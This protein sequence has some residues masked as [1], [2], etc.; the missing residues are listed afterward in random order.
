[1]SCALLD[2]MRFS[3]FKQRRALER[4]SHE[5]REL[6]RSKSRFTANIHHELRTPLTLML[7]PLE[8][9][10]SGDFGEIPKPVVAAMRTMRANGLRLL[11]LI[12]NLLDLAKIENESLS[13]RRMPVRLVERVTELIEGARPMAERKGIELRLEGF[14]E[15][16]VVYVDSDAFEKI[17][18]N[19]VGNSLKFTDQGQ[20]VVSG[21]VCDEGVHISVADTGIGI[22]REQLDKVF[23][24]FAQVARARVGARECTSCC[25]S[26]RPMPRKMR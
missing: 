26:G 24:R 8:A 11:K 9:L 13:I 2:R 20:I 15:M 21:E 12:N 22:P 6:D 7:S 16:P 14:E 23:D 1:M 17:V 18:V 4:A 3:D 19:L 5:L 10:M 25:R